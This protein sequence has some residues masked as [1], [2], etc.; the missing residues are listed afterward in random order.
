VIIYG[1]SI[2]IYKIPPYESI[3]HSKN[4]LRDILFLDIKNSS[5]Q[6]AK[7]YIKSASTTEDLPNI[8]S[9]NQGYSFYIAGHTYGKP[10]VESKGLYG[11][12]TDKFHLINKY[13]SIKFGF[14]LGDL[15]KKASNEAWELVKKDLNSL[16]PR[17]ENIIVPGNHD[18]GKGAHGALREIFLQQFGKTFFSFKHGKDLFIMLDGNISEWNISGEQLQFLKQSLPN[19]KDSTSNIFIFS[20]QLIWQ[21]SSKPEFKKIKPNSL[22]GRSNNLN[23]WDE[24]FP[25]FSD[26]TNNVYFFSGDIGAFPNGNELFYAKYLNV[27]FVATGMGGGMRDNFLIVSVI[28]D[29]VE[30]FFVPIN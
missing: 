13:Q 17:I 22:E 27:T 23:F 18:V 21:S 2:L 28:K 26:L 11:P 1:V 9:D 12:F 24:V 3:V 5:W 10:G 4:I 15:V 30:I 6:N 19:K 29:H 20:H 14:L 16:D 8:Q 7:K 25:L